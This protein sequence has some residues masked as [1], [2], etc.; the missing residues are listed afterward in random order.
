VLVHIEALA[1]A[2]RDLG[3]NFDEDQG[4]IR[5]AFPKHVRDKTAPLQW[6]LYEQTENSSRPRTHGKAWGYLLKNEPHKKLP[7]TPASM[8]PMSTSVSASASTA[9]E[10]NGGS[11]ATESMLVGQS[12]SAG[13]GAEKEMEGVCARSQLVFLVDEDE[14]MQTDELCLI[15][16]TRQPQVSAVHACTHYSAYT[17]AD[18]LAHACSS[19]H[20]HA[21]IH[22]HTRKHTCAFE[23][24]H[25]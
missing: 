1:D 7:S 25:A 11:T 21:Y 3:L 16:T 22:M 12:V 20:M 10:A 6:L 9:A 24:A 14:I 17:H 13:A 18:G 23:H 15:Q 8:L 2:L 19:I 4:Y 5:K